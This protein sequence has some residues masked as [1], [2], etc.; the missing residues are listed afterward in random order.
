V[1][2]VA[3][4]EDHPY[5]QC[6]GGTARARAHLAGESDAYVP[7]LVQFLGEVWPAIDARSKSA[8]PNI[9]SLLHAYFQIVQRPDGVPLD[10]A[11]LSADPLPHAHYFAPF[12]DCSFVPVLER[13]GIPAVI[14]TVWAF[15]GMLD[16]TG[17]SASDYFPLDRTDLRGSKAAFLQR[18][19]VFDFFPDLAHAAWAPW[20]D[21]ATHASGRP[22]DRKS[23]PTAETITAIFLTRLLGMRTPERRWSALR[24]RERCCFTCSTTT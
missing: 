10:S 11:N 4:L 1:L 20:A 22:I 9:L 17:R 24:L 15:G 18:P 5:M 16:D 6:S 8:V 3:R 19:A 21:G 23:V 14:C 7:A 12:A 2:N 13:E